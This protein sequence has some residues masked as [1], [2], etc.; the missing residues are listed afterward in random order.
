LA[1]PASASERRNLNAH[2]L[3]ARLS[4]FLWCSL[5]DAELRKLADSGDLVKPDVLAAQTR[6]L[7]ADTKAQRFARH[8]TEQWL[9]VD[10]IDA[11]AVNPERFPRF[12]DET[13]AA[14]RQE[15]I[16]FFRHVLSN[17]RSALEFLSADY[18]MVN[19]VL[20]T[21]YGLKG[22]DGPEF[23]K[24][25]V[26]PED[27]RGG[28]LTMGCFMMAHSNGLDSHP[29]H[30]GKW[31]LKELLNEPPPPPPPGVPE[32]DQAD[33]DFAKLPLKRQ[34]EIH[35]EH[36]ACAG[37]HAKLDPW[38]LALENYDAI[39]RWRASGPVRKA[40]VLPE[41][42]GK[43][44]NAKPIEIDLPAVDAAVTLPDSTA[45]NGA[46]Q[47]KAYCLTKKKDAFA[48]AL[49]RKLLAYSLGRS[50]E[51][52]DRA[53]VDRLTQRFAASDY[54]LQALITEIILGKPFQTR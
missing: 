36:V 44:D 15:P 48:K 52:T 5:P 20:A 23:R 37:C 3:A 40:T 11:V 1:E 8:F 2:E 16:E 13:K 42:D 26:R 41:S 18:A 31:V 27:H 24:V 28:L 32:L 39:G 47:L 19:E 7:L 43:R 45:I 53:E 29:I 4:Y 50:L 30:R 17:N 14:L 21:H 34:L 22:V 6:R 35:R 51:W 54:K 46:E 12:K 38:G 33:P 9:G 49:V 10:L 25:S